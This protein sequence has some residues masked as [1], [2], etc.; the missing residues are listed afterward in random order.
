MFLWDHGKFK[1]FI[2]LIKNQKKRGYNSYFEAAMDMPLDRII[3]IRQKYLNTVDARR[4]ELMRLPVSTVL[5]DKRAFQEFSQ[6]HQ[7]STAT[8]STPPSDK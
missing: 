4:E 5:Q 8:L 1:K 7:L 3:P 6:I 2:Q